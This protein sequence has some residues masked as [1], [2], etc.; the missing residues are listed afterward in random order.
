VQGKRPKG[1]RTLGEKEQD[2]LDALRVRQRSASFLLPLL[3]SRLDL[4]CVLV[5][6]SL[7][8]SWSS[9]RTRGA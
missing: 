3:T 5:H 4:R 6:A 9:A 2:F 1:R 8:L 7:V